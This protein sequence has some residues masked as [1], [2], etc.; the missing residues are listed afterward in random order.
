MSSSSAARGVGDPVS[1]RSAIASSGDAKRVVV[2]LALGEVVADVRQEL[3]GRVEQRGALDAF[4]C[5]CRELEDEP[6]AVGVPDPARASH[7]RGVERLEDVVHV[8]GDRPGRLPLGIAVRAEVRGE[9][10]EAVG[11][12][13]P[14]RA[15]ES[16]GRGH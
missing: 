7:A 2:P 15:G 14:R 8:R 16:G 13:A 12:A 1:S 3:D 5:Q 4:G 10:P 6:A 9:H 11:Q